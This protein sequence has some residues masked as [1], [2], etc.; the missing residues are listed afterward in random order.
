[1]PP[2]PGYKALSCPPSHLLVLSGEVLEHAALDVAG[3]TTTTVT[4]AAQR[5]VRH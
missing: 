1:V 5:L 4:P 3:L 2:P